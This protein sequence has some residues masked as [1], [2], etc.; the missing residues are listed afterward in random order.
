[1]TIDKDN[2]ETDQAIFRDL[3]NKSNDAIFVDDPQTGRFIFVNDKA[4]TSLGYERQ[5]LLKMGVMDIETTFP[6]NFSWQNH[7]NELRQ[8]GS[9]ML[10]GIQKR[11]N[12]TTIPVE[13]NISFVVLN[14]KEYIVAALRDI[15]ER[16]KAEESLRQ[17]QAVYYN[18][19]NNSE[20]AM[21]R[22]RLDGSEVLNANE[23]FLELVGQTRDEIIG[24]PA[25]ILWVDPN[26]REEMVRI[27]KANGRVVDFEFQMFDKKRGVR[28]C[29]TS[30]NLYPEEGILDGSIVDITERKRAEEELREKEGKYRVLFESANDG[31]FIQDE[32]GFTDC[33]QKAA[34]M[35]GLSKEDIMGRSPSEFA[36]ERQPDG[37]LSSEAAGEKIRTALSGVPQVFDWQ[38]VRADGSL[39]DVEVTLSRLELGGKMCLQAIIRD[40]SE[41][42]LL[43][44][45]ILRSQK[46]EAIGKLAGGIAHDFNNLLQG[47]FGYISMAKLTHDQK[48]KSLSM[49]EQAEEALH[50]SVNLT[51]QLLT[52]SKG[53]KPVKKRMKLEPVIENSARFALSGSGVDYRIELD[54]GLWAVEADEGQISQ[55]IQNIVI[56]ADQAMPEGGSLVIAAKNVAGADKNH[57]KIP[58]GNYVEISVQDTGIGIPGQHLKKIFDPYFT[59]KE[60]GS[61]LGLTTSYSIMRNHG[62]FIDVMS[63]S[64]KGTTFFIYLPAVEAEEEIT[65]TTT[66]SPAVRK[67]KI[68]VMDDEERIRNVAREL[69]MALGHEVDLAE[70]GETA[71]EKYHAAMKL[72]KPFDI[73]ILDLTVRGGMGGKATIELLRVID[74]GVKAIV[75]SGYSDDTVVADYE[76]YGFKARLTKPY[77]LD[78]LRDTLN[79]LLSS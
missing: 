73:V 55:V 3:I 78:G 44:Q 9:I 41:R 4:C 57:P 32:I 27:L 62:G 22:T 79:A 13:G 72:G 42:K 58:H 1:M 37:R 45:E 18:L 20:I 35:Y 14:T 66:A 60:R 49:L 51:S 77:K 30:L 2:I 71:I 70:H 63:E 38:A 7:V 40:I 31:I 46:L 11:K 69:I 56:N 67:G 8:R 59:T 17:S 28:D 39:F 65:E 25:T 76:K 33:N 75:S 6:D 10:E 61:G 50:M 54:N 68:L 74:P 64:G 12:G 52:F 34:D 47:V 29:L 36:P 16:K 23:K 19:F 26:R 21:F 24:S 15:T 5:E 53:G 43:E 48:E